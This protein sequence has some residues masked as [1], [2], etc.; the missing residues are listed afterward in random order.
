MRA[1]TGLWRW[2]HNPLRRGTDLAEAWVA[3]VALLLIVVAAPV[4]GIVAGTL[5]RDALYQSVREQHRTRH[6]V[7]AT[8]V[9]KVAQ[10]PLDPD[11]ETS[12]TRDAHT[13]V[14]ASWKAPDGSAHHGEVVS[15]LTT[16][17]KGEAF[18]LW[19]DAHGH[20]VNR[21]LDRPTALTHAVLAG[22]G[23]AVA[24]TGLVEGTRRVI[25]WRMVRRRYARW[26]HAWD[27]AGPDWGR[28]GTGS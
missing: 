18:P 15:S 20:V 25:V 4:V 17:H 9:K 10:P 24:V 14:V 19:T 23:A 11:P 7:T 22:F 16:P 12:T 2:R 6:A 1:I 27:I 8:V 21:P 13:R 28:T 5:S 26:E 3:L